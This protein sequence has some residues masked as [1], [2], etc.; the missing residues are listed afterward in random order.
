MCCVWKDFETYRLTVS[1]KHN[2]YFL[3]RQIINAQ[4]TGVMPFYNHRFTVSIHCAPEM[5]EIDCI[6]RIESF[7]PKFVR[8]W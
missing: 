7:W 2:K 1:V 5:S 6:D 8:G 3:V 4:I